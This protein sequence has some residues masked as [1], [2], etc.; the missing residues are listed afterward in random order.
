MKG[1][2]TKIVSLAFV[3]ALTST[4]HAVSYELTG[5]RLDNNELSYVTINDDGTIQ[6][7]IN[8]IDSIFDGARI[9]SD[10]LSFNNQA[11][12]VQMFDNPDGI[13]YASNYTD[14][15]TIVTD[16]GE[17]NRYASNL[18]VKLT[19]DANDNPIRF[20]TWGRIVDELTG[21]F[22]GGRVDFHTAV[23]R[24]VTSEVP[25]PM[26]MSLLG[27]GLIGGAIRRNKAQA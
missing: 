24:D 4:A 26:T 11:G 2:I 8:S 14:F 20:Q 12:A 7:V 19:L 21:G 25:E 6:F 17:T 27:M 16:D 1:L 5:S 18:F 23:G 3:L 10:I 22:I 15:G 9:E 13:E